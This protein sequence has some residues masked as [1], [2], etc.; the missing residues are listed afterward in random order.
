MNNPQ[1]PV[2]RDLIE[3]ILLVMLFVGLIYA[4]YRVLDVFFGV[5]TFAL[6]FS[7]SFAAAY[8]WIV[9]LLKG[10]RRLAAFIYSFILISIVALPLIYLIA[11]MSRH[12]RQLTPWLAMV[13]AQGL[14]PLPVYI[15][16]LPFA[17]SYMAS[18][19]A[20]FRESPK[21]VLGSHGQ[22]LNVILRH[23]IAGG[24][25]ILSVAVQFIIGIIISAFFLERGDN[26]LLPVKNAIK[27]LLSEKDGTDLLQAI[28]QAIRG[29]SI[30]VMGTGFIVAF[31][32]WTGLIIAGIPFAAGIAALIFFLV[33]IQV[34]ALVVW[35]PLIIWEFLQG[36]HGIAILFCVYL[37]LI[38]AVEMVV[39]PVLIAKSGKLP[40]L[41]LFLGVVGGLAAW[42]FTG[43]FKGAIITSIF[44]TIYSSWLER[45]NLTA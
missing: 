13:R 9:N 31:I 28:S 34:G 35:V 8:E 15:T 12:L 25:D 2:S 4:L 43:M 38:A 37:A 21:E 7:V 29:V 6:I 24:L 11:A 18:F 16:G 1:K 36:N 41:V 33:V 40:F 17:G 26:L 14:P 32:A 44:Y 30:G 5:L 3:T 23:I 39:R 22:Q 20:D 45:R 27:H 19:W 42:G 10:K